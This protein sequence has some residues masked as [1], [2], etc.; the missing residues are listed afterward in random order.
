MKK[1]LMICITL[2]FL[3]GCS[4]TG[5]DKPQSSSSP[6]EQPASSPAAS[7]TAEVSTAP[8][9]E[10]SATPV[11]KLTKEETADAVVQALK[12]KD[13]DGLRELIHPTKGIQFSPYVYIQ[14]DTAQKFQKDK[15]PSFDDTALYVWGEHDGSGETIELTFKEYYE[16]FI[17]DHDYA[18]SEK[19]GADEVIQTGNMVNNIKEVFPESYISDYHFSG[20]DKSFAGID[21]ASLIVVVEQHED[22][23]YVVAIARSQWTV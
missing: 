3:S 21:W 15:L 16:K 22:N 4:L 7:P 9:I 13:I 1:W 8:T 23:W 2:L 14:K 5:G 10:P 18:N 20:F 6:S 12:N 17:Y 11:K 19:V